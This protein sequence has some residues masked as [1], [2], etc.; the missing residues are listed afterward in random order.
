MM[1]TWTESELQSFA[2]ADDFHIS[3]YRQDGSTFGTPTFIWSVV[4][5]GDL[6]VRPYNGPRSRWY[7]CAIAQGGGRISLA[8]AEHEVAFTPADA[9]VL[10]AVDQ[11]ARTKYEGSPYVAPMIAEA[12][13]QATMRVA[14]QREHNE[15]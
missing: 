9:S 4:V 10:D 8:G 1:S 12:P 6:Y 11:A 5:D 7:R 2:T 13:R 15:R 14:P 3:P